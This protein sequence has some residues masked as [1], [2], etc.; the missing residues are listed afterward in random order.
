MLDLDFLNECLVC[1][2]DGHSRLA[3]DCQLDVHLP[4]NL[5]HDLAVHHLQRPAKQLQEGHAK[6][7]ERDGVYLVVLKMAKQHFEDLPRLQLVQGLDD[8][9]G[10]VEIG[11][12]RHFESKTVGE[13]YGLSD[14]FKSAHILLSNQTV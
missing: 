10:K 9:I 1:L 7:L 6:Q 5:H 11:L 14:S 8:A 4:Q 13:V 2:H 3:D 12:E